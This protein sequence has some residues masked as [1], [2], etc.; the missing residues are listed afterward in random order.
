M[1]NMIYGRKS[2]PEE[3]ESGTS[4]NRRK[5]FNSDSFCLILTLLVLVICHGQLGGCY[6]KNHEM[7][8]IDI[9]LCYIQVQGGSMERFLLAFI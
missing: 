9:R 6:V 3:H 2:F 5:K 4:A 1:L 7:I 8:N